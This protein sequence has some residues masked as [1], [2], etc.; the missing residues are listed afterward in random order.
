MYE[1]NLSSPYIGD[2]ISFGIIVCDITTEKKQ[3]MFRVSDV[4]V[5]KMVVKTMSE[6]C[7]KEQLE[8]IHL[9]D[10]IEDTI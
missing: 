8:P 6:L 10:V 1:E 7:T 5:D 4:A 2:Y 9:Y 3:E